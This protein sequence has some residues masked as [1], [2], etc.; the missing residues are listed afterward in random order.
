LDKNFWCS[1]YFYPTPVAGVTI[2]GLNS[3]SVSGDKAGDCG[4]TYKVEAQAG[5]NVAVTS[6]TC[7]G[8]ICATGA[9]FI[10]SGIPYCAD[11]K[12]VCENTK[13]KNDCSSV[14]DTIVSIKNTSDNSK[15]LQS[16]C[17]LR[18]DTLIISDALNPD[19]CIWGQRMYCPA[20]TTRESCL[21]GP[22]TFDF[23][24]GCWTQRSTGKE[25]YIQ[26]EG[27][28]FLIYCTDDKNA[29]KEANVICCS[30]ASGG[31]KTYS[32]YEYP[33]T[34]SSRGTAYFPN[35]SSINRCDAVGR[36]ADGRYESEDAKNNDPCHVCP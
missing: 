8:N 23:S 24:K 6:P 35:C 9:C 17:M 11:P 5:Q 32:I 19:E 16:S 27:P 20:G 13:N 31:N 21:S 12:K 14:N 29:N 1:Q 15:I 22:S 25:P 34:A 2:S 36:E 28:T 33:R 26:A 4:A 10:D 3:T 30:T 18:R 7:Y